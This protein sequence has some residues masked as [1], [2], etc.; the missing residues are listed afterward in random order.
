M[1]Q[2]T[3]FKDLREKKNIT[4]ES[5][6]K[7]LKISE[8][9][10]EIIEKGEFDKLPFFVLKEILRRYKIFFKIPDEIIKEIYQQ[11]KIKTTEEKNKTK[12]Q[13][14][15]LLNFPLLFVVFLILILFFIYQ[16]YELISPPV[17][18][19]IYPP[20]NFYS[21]YRQIAIKGYVDKRSNFFINKEQVFYDNKGYFEK[22]VILRQGANKFVLEAINYF[23]V[24]NTKVLTIYY[25]KY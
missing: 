18:R 5:L 12:T 7:I 22:N 16:F 19:I 24:K 21:P 17:I 14:R 11:Q 2:T 13:P 20:N 1:T 8:A 23:G 6:A 4:K 25:I 3:Y 15:F 10:I 9:Q